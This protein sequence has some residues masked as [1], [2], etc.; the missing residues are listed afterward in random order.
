M[1]GYVYGQIL[2]TPD[3]TETCQHDPPRSLRR[4]PRSDLHIEIDD[5]FVFVRCATNVDRHE[6]GLDLPTGVH[7][8]WCTCLHTGHPDG[9]R[10]NIVVVVDVN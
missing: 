7:S 2:Q 9:T 10:L 5:S 1:R 3:I 4:Q 8:D 6:F